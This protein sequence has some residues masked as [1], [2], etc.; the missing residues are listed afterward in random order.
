MSQQLAMTER[1]KALYHL[2]AETMLSF[3]MRRARKHGLR[4]VTALDDKAQ[5]ESY[6]KKFIATFMSDLES[7]PLTE[8]WLKE[9]TE[10]ATKN[11]LITMILDSIKYIDDQEIVN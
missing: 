4:L 6:V 10:E 11:E 9:L 2:G 1:E 3:I 5:L 8:E 7:S